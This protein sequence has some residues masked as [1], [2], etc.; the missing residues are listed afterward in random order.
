MSFLRPDFLWLLGA[1]LPLILIY[2]IK[3]KRRDVR[4]AS[5][6]IWER[7]A[8]RRALVRGRLKPEQL[9]SLLLMCIVLAGL[10]IAAAG[11]VAGDATPE[12]WIVDASASMGVRDVDGVSRYRSVLDHWSQDSRA[13]RARWSERGLERGG[14]GSWREPA[15]PTPEI[16]ALLDVLLDGTRL[17]HLW[18]DGGMSVAPR[19]D[20]VVHR[21]GSAQSRAYI[22]DAQTFP[23]ADATRIQVLAGC[24]G[25]AVAEETVEF[26]SGDGSVIS[27]ERWSIA[28]G[29]EQV[30]RLDGVPGAAWIR[31]AGEDRFPHGRLQPIRPVR[32]EPIPMVVVGPR[33]PILDALFNVAG[34]HV[35]EAGS[36]RI[37]ASRAEEVNRVS[38]SR[39]IVWLTD[40][41]TRD[42]TGIPRVEF[43]SG[44]G[45]L[46]SVPVRIDPG[47]RIA[48]A[49]LG[50]ETVPV[51]STRA[52]L[53]DGEPVL[54]TD[55]GP[56][57]VLRY[58][59]GAPVLIFGFSANS[60]TA[61]GLETLPI[62]LR[63][64]VQTVRPRPH[65]IPEW[66]SPGGL[67]V[68]RRPLIGTPAVVT[69]H[70]EE[71][72]GRTSSWEV[73]TRDGIP[74]LEMPTRSGRLAIR[75]S[76][77]EVGIAV[78]RPVPGERY[79][80]GGG[81]PVGKSTAEPGI[82]DLTV[83]FLLMAI[84]AF[85]LERFLALR[86]AGQRA[87]SAS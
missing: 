17:I 75:W 28:P 86:A 84:A 50:V 29:T 66:V 25:E 81:D 19:D 27:S 74:V 24:E 20:L 37:D 79:L 58:E 69:V 73:P 63:D 80:G 51:P 60:E 6:R 43:R 32:A 15:G 72:P 68:A 82:R 78:G 42:W 46:E 21:V 31:L 22:V 53:G 16:D 11:P 30:F 65:G 26:L 2:L 71:G 49:W 1:L 47:A 54:E 45:A 59:Q 18:T 44:G 85:F 39:G 33:A 77:G 61:L 48:P 13:E 4:V 87:E 76:Q 9:V 7:L 62:L 55:D 67:V 3:G 64:F 14:I 40:P 56:L 34:D 57:A 8:T 10:S 52:V 70:W 5:L 23:R 35:L 41:G 12:L 36:F 83:W 38:A